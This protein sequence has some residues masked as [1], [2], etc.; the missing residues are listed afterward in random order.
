MELSVKKWGTGVLVAPVLSLTILCAG[1]DTTLAQNRTLIDKIFS[2]SKTKSA[3]AQPIQNEE[4]SPRLV[5]LETAV[6]DLTAQIETLQLTLHQMQNRI[7]IL[8]GKPPSHPSL[9]KS[10]TSATQTTPL[11]DPSASTHETDLPVPSHTMPDMQ[12]FGS[13]R[14][15]GDGH[16]LETILPET[17]DPQEFYK[18]GYQYILA[19]DYPAA[20]QIFRAFQERF[21]ENQQIAD[22][23]FWLG[24]ALYAQGHYREAAQIYIDVERQH[25]SSP[26]GPENLLKLGMSL[27]QLQE[28]EVAC[29]T[30]S[31]VPKRYA[32]A[33]PAVIKRVNDEKNRLGCS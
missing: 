21:P 32:H 1:S 18:R 31:E 15:D 5:Q 25:Q 22:A 6:R 9:E 17:D 13:V 11:T 19:G 7:D 30:L 20:E 8:E 3:K 27:A 4:A 10:N 16:L 2:G 29:K 28:T 23:S 12:I 24:E 26:H 14:F 33:E